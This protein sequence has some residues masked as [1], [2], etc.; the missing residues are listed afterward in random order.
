MVCNDLDRD[1]DCIDN[2]VIELDPDSI[3]TYYYYYTGNY[4]RVSNHN[5]DD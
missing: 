2:N 4:D 3:R 1:C 5:P